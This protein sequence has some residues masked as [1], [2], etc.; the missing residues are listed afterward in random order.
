M[1]ELYEATYNQFQ[2]QS[3]GLNLN[4]CELA[5]LKAPA[6]HLS[7]SEY[8]FFICNFQVTKCKFIAFQKNIFCCCQ[9]FGPAVIS[10]N[11]FLWRNQNIQSVT[12]EF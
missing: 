12:I 6:M 1:K 2:K 4:V 7:T 11:N 3:S 5:N 9:I 10:E 8:I